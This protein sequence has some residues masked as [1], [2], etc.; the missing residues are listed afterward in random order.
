L[1]DSSE[2][3][4]LSQLRRAA[5]FMRRVRS[6]QA[7]KGKRF[8]GGNHL[9]A[10]R[11]QAITAAVSS[12]TLVA[13]LKES[14]QGDMPVNQLAERFEEMC[15][16]LEV[17]VD[18]SL[19]PYIVNLLAAELWANHTALPIPAE[20]LIS[21]TVH[22]G[23]IGP[24]LIKEFARF[25]K[26][27]GIFSQAASC[28]SDPRAF[29][30][31]VAKTIDALTEDPQFERFRETPNVFVEAATD[32]ARDPLGYLRGLIRRETNRA[33]RTGY[34]AARE[35]ERNGETPERNGP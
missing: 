9:R 5:E 19:R 23:A 26:T 24:K 34:W 17:A 6:A 8:V 25:R 15:R 30:C 11:E 2:D 3:A 31:R 13:A 29:L 1:S 28:P 22:Q 33:N 18:A 12:S 21:L 27:P 35:A 20:K 32:H 10:E 14:A 4:E 16:R 7:K